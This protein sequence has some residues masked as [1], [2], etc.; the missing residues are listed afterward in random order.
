MFSGVYW[1][2]DVIVRYA[3]ER[4]PPDAV[5]ERTKSTPTDLAE[6]NARLRAEVE[7]QNAEVRRLKGD[8]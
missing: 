7:R 5:A 2:E 3:S 8:G 1:T 4:E 6:E